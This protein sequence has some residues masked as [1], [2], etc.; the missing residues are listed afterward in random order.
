VE[1]RK[2]AVGKVNVMRRNKRREEG[3]GLRTED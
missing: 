3:G 1:E 2:E